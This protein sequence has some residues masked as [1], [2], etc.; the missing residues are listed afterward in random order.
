MATTPRRRYLVTGGAGFIGS[1]L[2]EALLSS[3]AA[4]TVVDDLS[5]GRE[6]NLDAA[7]AAV[8][9]APASV[10]TSLAKTRLR[11]H[12]LAEGLAHREA[13]AGVHHR[14]A[15]AARVGGGDLGRVDHAGHRPGL[16]K[17]A[18]GVHVAAVL[19]ADALEALARGRVAARDTSNTS[20]T[21]VARKFGARD[22]GET[23]SL[24]A[25]GGRNHAGVATACRDSRRSWR[26]QA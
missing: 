22:C 23:R 9:A 21:I 10:R 7:R 1:H 6:G 24:A 15:A 2:C 19:V 5:T 12:R 17:G 3:G 11:G 20:N 4:V 14:V 18:V 26:S 13:H 16:L 25:I 8:K